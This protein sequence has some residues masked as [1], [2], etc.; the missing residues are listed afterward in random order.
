MPNNVPVTVVAPAAEKKPPWFDAAVAET[1]RYGDAGSWG[2]S[3]SVST[4][5]RDPHAEPRPSAK[6]S[7]M[8]PAQFGWTW[9]PAQN[10]R[11]IWLD[12]WATC[13]DGSEAEAEA[14]LVRFG[15]Q[16][17]RDPWGL[18]FDSS[19]EDATTVEVP[20][21]E[22]KGQTIVYESGAGLTGNRRLT[23]AWGTHHRRGVQAGTPRPPTLSH[24]LVGGG[25][26]LVHLLTARNFPRA[27]AVLLR[28]TIA[29][30]DGPP[31][32]KGAAASGAAAAAAA[33]A[34]PVP[35]S[36]DKG[37]AQGETALSM[38][39]DLDYPEVAAVLEACGAHPDP[40]HHGALLSWLDV[41][42]AIADTEDAVGREVLRRFRRV[43]VR[44]GGPHSGGSTSVQVKCS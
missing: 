31:A 9:A 16:G 1:P 41:W 4:L 24:V 13:R 8:R 18:T 22:K 39:R 44:D 14:A 23:H 15:E 33:S 27:L 19:F 3:A 5:M 40:S 36:V 34:A 28:Q 38:A 43:Q 6:V 10:Q 21:L 11:L 20:V 37:S 29:P 35:V 26:G 12:L 30:P 32:T 2:I 17:G 25:Y 7:V 42:R